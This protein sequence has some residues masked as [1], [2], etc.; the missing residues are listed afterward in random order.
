MCPPPISEAL[1]FSRAPTISTTRVV[2]TIDDCPPELCHAGGALGLLLV[3]KADGVEEPQGLEDM[4]ACAVNNSTPAD[5]APRVAMHPYN[6]PPAQLPPKLI[7]R[8]AQVVA[9]MLQGPGRLDGSVGCG[10]G[11]L[12]GLGECRVAPLV[13]GE[14]AIGPG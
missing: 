6:Q 8:Y 12:Q 5:R 7:V 2:S 4:K 3:I 11:M 9:G 10:L 14:D 1:A 13:A